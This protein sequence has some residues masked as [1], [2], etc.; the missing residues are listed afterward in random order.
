MR[1][2]KIE[3]LLS[4][5]YSGLTKSEFATLLRAYGVL[6]KKEA[7]HM[8]FENDP[9]RA[10]FERKA[11]ALSKTIFRTAAA[12]DLQQLRRGLKT[13]HGSRYASGLLARPRRLIPR[14]RDGFGRRTPATLAAAGWPRVPA[15]VS[16]T[17]FALTLPGLLCRLLR[18]CILRRE[19]LPI[20]SMS[21]FQRVSD[22]PTSVIVYW[23]LTLLK[24]SQRIFTPEIGICC[25]SGKITSARPSRCENEIAPPLST[26]S[27]TRKL[28]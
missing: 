4:P 15:Q 1:A 16:P 10:R 7:E 26:V 17:R 5:I 21:G 19:S 3:I 27:E 13:Y 14:W 6:N 12:R 18:G 22:L 2:E 28:L 11:T 23:Q 9:W 25:A 24:L 20:L 8:K